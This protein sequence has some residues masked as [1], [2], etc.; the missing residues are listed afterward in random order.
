MP[1]LDFVAE[2]ARAVL[3]EQQAAN[4]HDQRAMLRAAVHLKSVLRDLLSALDAAEA[5]LLNGSVR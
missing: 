4:I 5:G 3:A 2:Q 1:S